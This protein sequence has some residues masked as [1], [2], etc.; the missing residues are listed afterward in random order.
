MP[1]CNYCNERKAALQRPKTGDK[2]CKECFFYRFE[3]EIHETI[4]TNQLFSPG[5]RVRLC[6]PDPLTAAANQVLRLLY[7][8][9]TVLLF[10]TPPHSSRGFEFNILPGVHSRV[11]GQGQHCIGPRSHDAQQASQLWIGFVFAFN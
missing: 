1:P 11:G 6:R 2:I 3:E 8:D 10:V 9:P 5:E 4:V 7:M